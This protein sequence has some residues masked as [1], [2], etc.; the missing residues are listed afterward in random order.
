M[1]DVWTSIA[2]HIVGGC[3]WVDYMHH[4]DTLMIAHFSI[5]LPDK[6]NKVI[7]SRTSPLKVLHAPNHREIKGTRHI[8]RAVEEL[9][10]EGFDID[11]ILAERVPNEEVRRLIY[12]ADVVVDQLVIG[13]YAMFAIEAMSS[14]TPVICHLRNDLVSLYV[15]TSLLESF[16]EI[17]IIKADSFSIKEVL[18]QVYLDRAILQKAAE[19]GRGYVERHHSVEAIS[20]IFGKILYQLIGP[21]SHT[22]TGTAS[23]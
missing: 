11:L 2:N 9:R 23:R 7:E 8:I 5:S 21:P 14:N 6:V 22:G 4:W 16:D 19:K 10:L 20:L 13:W 17:P 18:K 12:E 15:A 3:E 1:I